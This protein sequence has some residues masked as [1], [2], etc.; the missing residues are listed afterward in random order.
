MLSTLFYVSRTTVP[1]GA[2][3]LQ[4]L[5]GA[6]QLRNRRADITG[7][8]A[9]TGH[10]FA[11]VLEGDTVQVEALVQKIAADTRHADIRVLQRVTPAPHRRFAEWSMQFLDSP[12][13]DDVLA[14]LR[15]LQD[16]DETLVQWSL[17][18]ILTLV[19]WNNMDDV[20]LPKPGGS[21]PGRQSRG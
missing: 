20:G 17:E 11:Q 14:Q 5:V 7:V 2:A 3:A 18:R 19:R 1:L 15:I 16:V 9:F 12:A 13:L 21:P 6:A 10:H 4:A 8:L